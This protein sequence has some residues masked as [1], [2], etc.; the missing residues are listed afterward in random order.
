MIALETNWMRKFIVCAFLAAVA[1]VAMLM[2]PGHERQAKAAGGLFPD[3]YVAPYC[4]LDA[5]IDRINEDGT[6]RYEVECYVYY[7]RLWTDDTTWGA[8]WEM[9]T[10][11]KIPNGLGGTTD[12]R[13]YIKIWWEDPN[14]PGVRHEV[15][16]TTQQWDLVDIVDQNEGVIGH[17]FSYSFDNR[18]CPDGTTI[19]NYFYADPTNFHNYDILYKLGDARWVDTY[20]C[21]MGD[22]WDQI[23]D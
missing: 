14:N 15:V 16:E 9:F 22:G 21:N 20:V 18:P 23:T 7:N 2:V 6:V 17:H 12:C 10:V 4:Y 19:V 8:D 13:P 11:T 3:Y 5:H 1:A